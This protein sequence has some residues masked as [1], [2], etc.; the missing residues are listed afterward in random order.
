VSETAKPIGNISA[1]A[2]RSAPSIV[3][4]VLKVIQQ[5]ARAGIGVLLIEQMVELALEI[6]DY[7]FVMHQGRLIGEGEA[8]VIAK[9]DLLRSAY[10]GQRSRGNGV[11]EIS[12]SD[13]PNAQRFSGSWSILGGALKVLTRTLGVP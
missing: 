2:G 11:S 12:C 7:A 9:S 5:L 3:E 13:P 4:Q 6:S 10:L 8:K 1:K